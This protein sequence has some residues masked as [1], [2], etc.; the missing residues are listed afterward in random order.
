MP[1]V[2][3]N[4]KQWADYEWTADGHEWTIGYGG[5][6][7]AWENVVLPRIRG[8]LP[9]DRILEI[10]PGFGVWTERLRPFAKSM[11]LVDL[12]PRCIEHCRAKFGEQVMTY[13]VN[14]GRSL[15]GVQDDSVD[16]VFSW[17]SLVHAEQDVM[18]DYVVQLGK[19]LRVG[20]AGV[21]HHS[22]FGAYV[23]PKTGEAALPNTHWRGATMTADLFQQF[24]GEAGLHCVCQELVPWG[25]P[26]LTDVFSAFV[27]EPPG[28]ARDAAFRIENP[29]FWDMVR[30]QANL[31]HHYR[32][33]NKPTS[34][35]GSHP[36]AEGHD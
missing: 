1:T 32:N 23:D 31:P 11:T 8:F 21:I 24:C 18:R 2:D 27:R 4:L 20:G 10:A 5:T 29:H 34:Q 7:A 14:D 35:S 17:H 19:K 16:F 25:Y 28:V 12:T 36:S 33:P 15:D 3:E 13:V 26:H 6:D 22:N 30:M 9:A